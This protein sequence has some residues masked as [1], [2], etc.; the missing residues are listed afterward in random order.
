MSPHLR[1]L[2]NTLPEVIK[3]ALAPNTQEKYERAWKSWCGFCE[4]NHIRNLP[5]DPFFIA[6]HF[7]HLLTTNGSRGSVIDA[8]YGLRWGHHAAGFY[9]PTDHPFVQLAFEGAK[10]LQLFWIKKKGPNDK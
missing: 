8:F 5:S 9:S 6:V 2:I 4:V 10:R 7:N 1:H 3:A